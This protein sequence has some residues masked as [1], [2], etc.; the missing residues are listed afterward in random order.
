MDKTEFQEQRRNKI[1]EISDE[2]LLH[3]LDYR[4]TNNEFLFHL[5][6]RDYSSS[7][8]TRFARGFWFQGSDYIWFSPYS[9]GDNFNK[10]RSIGFV[11][12]F[13]KNNQTRFSKQIAFGGQN[14]SQLV[15][16]YWEVADNWFDRDYEPGKFKYKKDYS[17]QNLIEALNAFLDEDVVLI[18]ALILKYNYQEKFFPKK[19]K[20]Q[21]NLE[22]TLAQR[23]KLKEFMEILVPDIELVGEEG[24]VRTELKWHKKRERDADFVYKYK[25]KHSNIK[26]CPACNLDIMKEY[27]L[28]PI[29]VLEL[30]HIVPLSQNNTDRNRKLTE[31][32]VVL[33]C[34]TCHRVIHKLMKERQSNKITLEEFK[35][36][37]T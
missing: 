28:R 24:A 22:R 4:K 36:Y 5:R 16:F 30:H 7:K 26:R 3:L 19:E 10:T 23:I 32:D 20:F 13:D 9:Q 12:E 8:E 33:L 15:D 18:N 25:I 14:N 29:E 35:S 6:Q 34:P 27:A 17:N 11:I 31:D 2:I 21:K 1:I 37:L